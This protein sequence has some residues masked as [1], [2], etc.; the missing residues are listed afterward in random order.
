[1]HAKS[2]RRA[3]RHSFDNA[4][5]TTFQFKLFLTSGLKSFRSCTGRY[6]RTLQNLKLNVLLLAV[7]LSSCKLAAS[8]LTKAQE[9]AQF[10]RTFQRHTRSEAQ[11]MPHWHTQRKNLKVLHKARCVQQFIMNYFSGR[12]VSHTSIQRAASS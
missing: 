4:W 10:C 5:R 12:R 11:Q 8:C 3:S 6:K 2:D 7:A 1:M 9:V